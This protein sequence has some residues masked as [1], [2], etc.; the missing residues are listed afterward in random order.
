MMNEKERV[1]HLPGGGQRHPGP[2]A[3]TSSL[4]PFGHPCRESGTPAASRAP[5]PTGGHPCRESGTLSVI[6]APLPSFGHPFRHSGESRNPRR[7][8]VSY[9]RELAQKHT[10]RRDVFD[11]LAWM[12]FSYLRSCP[13]VARRPELTCYQSWGYV[14]SGFRRKDDGDG[15]W[16]YVDSGFCRKDD[17]DEG[18]GLRGIRLSPERR[19]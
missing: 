5:L 1:A 2:V 15:G 16:D 9:L 4:P 3:M 13:G 19:W 11:G 10:A 7:P 12:G 6:R 8:P 18:L 17:G 14:D